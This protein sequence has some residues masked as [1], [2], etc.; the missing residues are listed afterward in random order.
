MSTEPPELPSQSEILEVLRKHPLIKLR[1]NVDRAFVVGST[2]KHYLGLGTVRPDSDFDVLLEIRQRGSE[3]AVETEVRY[4]KKLM[5]HF[6]IKN[7]RGRHDYL[8][9]QWAGRR[10]DVYFTFNA[11]ME[12]RP[13]IE[14]ERP[15]P[16]NR[17]RPA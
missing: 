1:E 3:D 16:K 10:V 5:D 2:A 14:L 15:A 4:R 9:P 13:K 17:P 11:D 12:S 8:H 7:L 6:A